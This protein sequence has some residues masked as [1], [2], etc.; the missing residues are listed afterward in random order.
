MISTK[1]EIIFIKTILVTIGSVFVVVGVAL[2]INS[3]LGSD[4]I[5]V[6]LDGL[7][8]TF[9]LSLGKASLIN[10][11]IVLLIALSFAR[12]YI[13]IGTLIGALLTG[14]LLGIVDP[15]VKIIFTTSP[16]LG[17]RVIMIVAGQIILCLGC[18]I[19]LCTKFGFGTTDA[20]IVTIC[21]KFNLKYKNLKMICD[22]A[23]TV[24]GMLL[25]GIFGV[26]SIFGAVTGGTLITFFMRIIDRT[27][28]KRLSL[29]NYEE[30]TE[31]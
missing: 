21:D 30:R 5:S 22:A 7:S 23:Y 25:G 1:W 6:W 10:N 13:H 2:F 19:N 9:H 20:I 4:P 3:T 16:S 15:L 26:G 8:R 17:M 12:K 29:N 31:G 11:I 14:P 24:S 18:A 28:I 27:I